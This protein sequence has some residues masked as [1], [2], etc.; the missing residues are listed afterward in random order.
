MEGGQIT[1]RFRSHLTLTHALVFLSL[2]CSRSYDRERCDSAREGHGRSCTHAPMHSAV[3]AI[4]TMLLVGQTAAFLTSSLTAIAVSQRSTN[5]L[6]M[7]ATKPDQLPADAKR[8]YVRPDRFL[9]VL[10]SAPQLL[11]RLGSGAL[12][13]GY[14]GEESY[15][16][17]QNRGTPSFPH[18]RHVDTEHVISM[19]ARSGCLHCSRLGV[20]DL[21]VIGNAL[22]YRRIRPSL[23]SMPVT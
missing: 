17:V 13:D 9:D 4:A 5:K 7:A 8:Y 6:S 10:T 16:S 23:H 12:V 2:C 15:R 21:P 1:P 11:F 19:N 22:K 20:L 18:G 3:S 14:T